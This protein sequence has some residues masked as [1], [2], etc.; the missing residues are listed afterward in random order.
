MEADA[1]AYNWTTL[2]RGGGYKCGDLVLQVGG[3]SNLRQQN[4]VMSTVGLGPEID[5]AGEDQQ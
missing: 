4:M 3:V 1:W 2:F 5:C